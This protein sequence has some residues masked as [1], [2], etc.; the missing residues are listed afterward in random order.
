MSNYLKSEGKV[1]SSGMDDDNNLTMKILI[2]MIAGAIVGLI[3]Q[4]FPESW[5]VSKYVTNGIL[6]IGGTIFINLM[7]LL[8]VPIVLVSLTCGICSLEDIK[9]IGSVGWKSIC[10]FIGT[11]VVAIII[12]LIFA[13]LF[14]LGVGQHLSPVSGSVQAGNIPTLYDLLINIVPTN[15]FKAMADGDMLQIIVFAVLFGIAINISGASG[16]R[17]T[18]FLQDFN[19][20]IMKMIMMVMRFAPYGV[21][22]LIAILFA[23]FG[24]DLLR[25]LLNY[26]LTVLFVLVVHTI[27]TYSFLLKFFCKLNPMTFFR[28][29][30]P[31]ILFSFSTSSSN[32]SI[33]ITLEV[34]EKKIGLSSVISS[35]VI[36]LGINI[37]KNGTAIMQGVASI[38]IANAYDVHI[39]LVGNLIIVLTATLAS[40][41]TGGVPSVGIMALIIVLRQLGVPIEGIALILGIDRL[42]DM[43]RTS[44]NVLGNAVV[45]C[46]VGKSENE[47]DV[48]VYNK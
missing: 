13:N 25:Q 22:C 2:G 29:M 36:P 24:F 8:V 40:I 47:L 28:K 20:V 44:V 37:N 10:L 27:L 38:F 42:L 26:F 16:K 33:P 18:S 23:K 48:N 14:Q 34:A 9:K 32:A 12:A 46:V 35:F 21:F 43:A 15:L 39:G 17:V 30:Y 45:A 41:G 19:S 1:K 31:V 3:L 4:L 11:T 5:A 7:R 6:N